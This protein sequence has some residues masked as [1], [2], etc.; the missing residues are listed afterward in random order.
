MVFV[1]LMWE[2]GLAKDDSYG[3]EGSEAFSANG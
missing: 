2:S 3:G 1:L